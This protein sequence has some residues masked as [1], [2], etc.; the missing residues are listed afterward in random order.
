M[1]FQSERPL[2][3]SLWKL[4]AQLVY[5]KR[6]AH[7][8]NWLPSLA[9]TGTPGAVGGCGV[10]YRGQ[11]V[12]KLSDSPGKTMCHDET[13]LAYLRQVFHRPAETVPVPIAR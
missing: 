5:G 4:A 9:L 13:F 10:S 8:H 12:A 11:P 1:K 2:R 7:F 6:R 3:R